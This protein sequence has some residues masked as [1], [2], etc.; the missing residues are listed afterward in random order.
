VLVGVSLAFAPT[1]TGCKTDSSDSDPT[2]EADTDTDTDADADT[3]ADT[4]SDTDVDT[5]GPGA[6]G[7]TGGFA[8]TAPPTDSGQV[9]TGLFVFDC[10]TGDT[11]AGGIDAILDCNGE[12][13]PADYVGDGVICDDGTP[14]PWGAPDFACAAFGFDGGDCPIPDTGDTAMSGGT[15]DTANPIP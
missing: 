12:C 2:P 7:D 9:E 13:Y 4:D 15:G 8:D 11:A 3:D 14:Q 5:A 1:H 10:A 6:T